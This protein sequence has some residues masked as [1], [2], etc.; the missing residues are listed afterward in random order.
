M[1]S[2]F[3]SPGLFPETRSGVYHHSELCFAGKS[4]VDMLQISRGK[5]NDNNA[6]SRAFY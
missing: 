3:I 5:N 6:E 4:A 2:V 1:I